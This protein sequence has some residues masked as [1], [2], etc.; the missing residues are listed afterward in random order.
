MKTLSAT[1][2]PYNRQKAET[3]S[4]LCVLLVLGVK[5]TSLLNKTRQSYGICFKGAFF[6]KI[7]NSPIKRYGRFNIECDFKRSISGVARAWRGAVRWRRGGHKGHANFAAISRRHRLLPSFTADFVVGRC[8]C[9]PLTAFVV[10]SCV[11]ASWLSVVARILQTHSATSH[12][13]FKT[14]S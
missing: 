4:F 14:S 9:L 7:K 12:A 8:C 6:W 11:G 2:G 10:G 1:P 13:S 3:L 5:L